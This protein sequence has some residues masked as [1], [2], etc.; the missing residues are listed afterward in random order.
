VLGGVVGFE[1][2]ALGVCFAVESFGFSGMLL[3]QLLKTVLV[4]A[5]ERGDG[6]VEALVEFPGERVACGFG[7][8]DG[9]VPFGFQRFGAGEGFLVGVGM[10]LV[11]LIAC[12][13]VGGVEQFVGVVEIEGELAGV[14]FG[15]LSPECVED[16]EGGEAEDEGGGGG[17]PRE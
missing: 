12:G 11:V 13:G 14:M 1:G 17:G 5:I 15:E 7:G 4:E 2:G 16:E 3:G 6:P 8:L 10:D 9:V